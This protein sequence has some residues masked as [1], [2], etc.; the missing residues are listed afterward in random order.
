MGTRTAA[1]VSESELEAKKVAELKDMLKEKG[2]P[3]T[4][5]KPDLIAR[6][7]EHEKEADAAMEESKADTPDQKEDEKMEDAKADGEK[8]EGDAEMKEEGGDAKDEEG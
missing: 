2:L 5:N 3:Q 8:A 4:G 6:L 7:L 1:M